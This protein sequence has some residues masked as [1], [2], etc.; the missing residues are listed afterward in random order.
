MS[1]FLAKCPECGCTFAA[2]SPCPQCRWSDG[3]QAVVADDTNHCEEF[4]RR[5]K[6]H[7]RNTNIHMML[8]GAT[9]FAGAAT[10]LMWVLF[11]YR[12]NVLGL[13]MIG[14]LMVTSAILG[15][16]TFLA[17]TK[18]PTTLFCPACD[19]ELSDLGMGLD[20]CPAC[21]VQLIADPNAAPASAPEY[22]EIE[23]VAEEPVGV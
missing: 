9:G 7:A 11:L 22:A 17:K 19:G 23:E 13:I 1:S 6:T 15:A 12:G 8:L 3:S 5:Q 20:I 18:Y 10:A 16:C 14:I 4:A 2:G 21:E